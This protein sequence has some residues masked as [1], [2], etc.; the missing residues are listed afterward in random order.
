MC[1]LLAV[2]FLGAEH[3]NPHSAGE[4]EAAIDDSMASDH[5]ERELLVFQSSAGAAA[6]LS[7]PLAPSTAATV[8]PAA[9][10][11]AD[12][13][14]G[15]AQATILATGNPSSAAEVAVGGVSVTEEFPGSVVWAT[16]GGGEC[17]CSVVVFP[18]LFLILHVSLAS[19]G[20]CFA[21]ACDLSSALLLVSLSFPCIR[22]NASSLPPGFEEYPYLEEIS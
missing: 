1:R 10:A 8:E 19:S 13:A 6:V 22:S 18:L 4:A 14:P 7:T 12:G 2:S 20:K 15:G 17:R 9:H 3:P 11:A 5:Y 16:R 21:T